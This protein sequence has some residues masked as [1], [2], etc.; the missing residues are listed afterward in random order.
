MS[1]RAILERLLGHPAV[2]EVRGVLDAY[3]AAPGGL[4][5]SGLAYVTLFTAVPT[6]LLLLGIAGFVARDEGFQALLVAQASAAFPPL[7]EVLDAALERIS[8]GAAAS[9][10]V[11]IIGLVWAVSQFY[12]SLDV[13]FSR[14]W[15]NTPERGMV[16]RTLRGFAWVAILVGLVV[17]AVVGA[18]VATLLDAVLPTDVP[19]A[20]AVVGLAGSPLAMIA[21]A[22]G[23]VAA[24]YRV[25]PPLLPPWRAVVPPAIVAGLAITLLTQ[26]FAVLAPVVVGAAEVVGSLAAAFIALAW[27][28]FSYQALLLGAAWVRQRSLPPEGTAPA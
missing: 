2:A 22:I 16:G 15:R 7:A 10:I 17:L 18:S 20:S 19:L 11:G 23:I 14:I 5:A 9:S 3:G 12:G 6:S 24:V 1:P 21:V 28:S 26:A 27:L 25:L 13:A 8:Q 4:I